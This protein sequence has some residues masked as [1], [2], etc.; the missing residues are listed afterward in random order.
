MNFGEI[1]SKLRKSRNMSQADL[2]KYL[3]VSASTI[4]MYEQGRRQPDFEIEEAIADFF[5]VSLDELRGIK[6]ETSR[7]ADYSTETGNI[8]M[9][10]EHMTP[11]ERI[12]VKNFVKFIIDNRGG[13][14]K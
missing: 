8:A 2:A 6:H 3:G 14:D 10:I 4:G 5:N 13:D 7:D 12:Q 1:L 9:L 11:E